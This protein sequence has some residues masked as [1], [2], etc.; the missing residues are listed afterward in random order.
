MNNA[1]LYPIYKLA[2][3]TLE[4]FY[5]GKKNWEYS[6]DSVHYRGL[7]G[8]RNKITHPR[9][10]NIGDIYLRFSFFQDWYE[11]GRKSLANTQRQIQ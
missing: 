3:Y 8:K 10:V 9:R 6:N 5:S 2:T 7:R 1:I 11:S 4:N